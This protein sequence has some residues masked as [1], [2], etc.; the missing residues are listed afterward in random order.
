MLASMATLYMKPDEPRRTVEINLC[1]WATP[2]LYR[3]FVNT[4]TCANVGYMC[5]TNSECIDTKEGLECPCSEGFQAFNGT[6]MDIDECMNDSFICGSNAMCNNT[7]GGFQCTT[8][9][10]GY[11]LVDGVCT[12]INECAVNSTICGSDAQCKNIDGGFLCTSCLAGFEIV[13]GTCTDMNE[14]TQKNACP[15]LLQC[16]NTNGTYACIEKET[17]DQSN[18]FTKTVEDIDMFWEATKST[19]YGV[20]AVKAW[21]DA[22]CA[23]SL[24]M[25]K[26]MEDIDMSWEAMKST[27]FGAMVVKESTKYGAMAVKAWADAGCACS[28]AMKKAM[29]NIDMLWEASKST[30]YGAMIVKA[31]AAAGEA[32]S[33]VMKEEVDIHDWVFMVTNHVYQQ[34]KTQLM[35]WSELIRNASW[36]QLILVAG[37]HYVAMMMYHMIGNMENQFQIQQMN[38]AIVDEEEMDNLKLQ[39]EGAQQDLGRVDDNIQRVEQRIEEMDKELLMIKS[40][41]VSIQM[42]KDRLIKSMVGLKKE[43]ETIQT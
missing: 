33:Q 8:C 39:A 41:L 40:V 12:D 34:V 17:V 22:E 21:A 10:K 9:A 27:K 26:T 38:K 18:W 43:K 6:C 16:M 5:P 29:N 36:L 37:V 4:N 19:K 20:M 11:Q 42:E 30:E 25:K 35:Y 15:S 23:C 24:A 31:W 7:K 28:L 2:I 1:L 32:C 14:C 3:S 13:N